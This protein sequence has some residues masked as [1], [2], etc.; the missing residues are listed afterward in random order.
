MGGGGSFSADGPGKG[1]L[2][3]LYTRLLNQYGF[4][5]SANCFNHSYTTS[6]LLESVRA[7][8]CMDRCTPYASYNVK[9]FRL[10]CEEVSAVVR[11]QLHEAEVQRAKN[12]LRS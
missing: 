2:S 4:L 8:A 3:R 7:R 10:L 12:M 6:G 9:L 5:E 11:G 1:M